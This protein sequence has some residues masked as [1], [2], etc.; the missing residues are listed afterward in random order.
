MAR[1]PFEWLSAC[2][3][4]KHL[5]DASH[6]SKSSEAFPNGVE[7]QSH[8]RTEDLWGSRVK[9]GTGTYLVHTRV[10]VVCFCK[11]N[12]SLMTAARHEI[13]CLAGV[14]RPASLA[15]VLRVRVVLLL[16]T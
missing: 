11:T 5:V 15:G 12:I 7:K 2:S 8:A 3:D 16:V 9:P 14:L 1:N 13:T 10:P 4:L 6:W